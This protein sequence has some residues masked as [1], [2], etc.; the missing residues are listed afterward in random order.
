MIQCV[1]SMGIWISLNSKDIIAVVL[2]L[3]YLSTLQVSLQA[4]WYNFK[5][6]EA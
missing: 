6:Q 4:S 5:T 2:F 1:S 3:G